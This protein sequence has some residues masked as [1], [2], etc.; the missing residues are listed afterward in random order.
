MVS[1][2]QATLDDVSAIAHIVVDSWRTTYAG[3]VPDSYLA[4]L[5]YE[6]RENQFRHILSSTEIRSIVYVAVD[7]PGKVIGFANGGQSLENNPDYT[8]QLYTIYLPKDQQGAGVGGL[9]IRAV[10]KWLLETGYDSMLVWVLKDNP[11][12]G[13]YEH[14][15]G[16]YITEKGIE[17]GG[18]TLPEI[19]YGWPDLRTLLGSS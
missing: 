6:A 9:L 8:A 12:R 7:D 1:I 16:Q 18:V 2:R 13:F 17:I 3:I 5:S 14:L 15:G 11:A 4:N 19:A 10:A